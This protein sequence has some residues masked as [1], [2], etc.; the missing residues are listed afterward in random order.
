MPVPR[1]HHLSNRVSHPTRNAAP[2]ALMRFGSP[3]LPKRGPAPDLSRPRD[4]LPDLPS[5]SPAVSSA[6]DFAKVEALAKEEPFEGGVF[7]DGLV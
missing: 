6:V 3:K 7:E 1:Q 4:Q 5:V 2:P